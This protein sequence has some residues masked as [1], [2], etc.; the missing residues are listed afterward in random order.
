MSGGGLFIPGGGPAPPRC[1]KTGK[2]FSSLK[3]AFLDKKIPFEM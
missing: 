3:F 2:P 1:F